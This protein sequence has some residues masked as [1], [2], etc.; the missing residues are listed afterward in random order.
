MKEED[1]YRVLSL[2]S[3][4]FMKEKNTLNLTPTPLLLSTG[5]ELGKMLIKEEWASAGR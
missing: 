2:I 5:K 1:T 4:S 3:E